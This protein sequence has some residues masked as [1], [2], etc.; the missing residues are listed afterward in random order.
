[1]RLGHPPLGW[2]PGSSP[3]GVIHL[4]FGHLQRAYYV[5][6]SVVSSRDIAGNRTNERPGSKG[7]TKDQEGWPPATGT[8]RRREVQKLLSIILEATIVVEPQSVGD[9]VVSLYQVPLELLT[10][11]GTAQVYHTEAATVS[12][13]WA[14]TVPRQGQRDPKR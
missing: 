2:S 11:D 12:G 5:P 8:D 6:G 1:M 13:D 14:P 3:P 4:F 9:E 10:G 7:A